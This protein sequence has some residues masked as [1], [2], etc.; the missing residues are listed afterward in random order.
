MRKSNQY[1]TARGYNILFSSPVMRITASVLLVSLIAFLLYWQYFA[2]KQ[3][4]Y[5]AEN[6]VEEFILP[7]SSEM[8]LNRN[9]SAQMH[10]KK[11]QQTGIT[12]LSGEGAFRFHHDHKSFWLAE[13]DNLAIRTTGAVFNVRAYPQE[14]QVEVT[15]IEGEVQFYSM[16]NEGVALR[17]GEAGVYHK[18]GNQFSRQKASPNAMAYHTLFFT[19]NDVTLKTVAEE[20]GRVYHRSVLLAEHLSNCRL[21]ASFHQESL[22]TILANMAETLNLVI[23]DDGHSITIS[24]KGRPPVTR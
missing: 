8:I 23:T 19:F 14:E 6:E 2:V 11:T 7:D 10:Y 1:M 15:V 9:S 24:G 21:T 4:E 18:A 13:V 22:E 12:R 16:T 5:A 20:L 17:S 3:E